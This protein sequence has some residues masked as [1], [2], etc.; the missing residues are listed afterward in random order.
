MK[1]VKIVRML[2]RAARNV[3]RAPQGVKWMRALRA[4]GRGTMRK[5]VQ[6]IRAIDAQKELNI[7]QRA[8]LATAYVG[9]DDSPTAR[10]IFEQIVRDTEAVESP[11]RMYVNRYARVYLTLMNGSDS[12]EETISEAISINCKSTWKEVLPLVPAKDQIAEP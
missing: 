10:R 4:Y 2:F 7:E 1:I 9:A 6:L 11:E 12:V 3:I 8:V 5:T